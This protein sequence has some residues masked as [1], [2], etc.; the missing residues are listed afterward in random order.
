MSSATERAES[1]QESTEGEKLEDNVDGMF[2]PITARNSSYEERLRRHHSAS[3]HPLERNW[4]LN[5]GYSIQNADEEAVAE[6][7]LSNK[8]EEASDASEGFV[9]SWDDNDPMNP[10]N[11]NTVRRWLIVIICSAGSLCV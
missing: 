5:D 10:R 2:A 9:V 6:R 11:F 4:S 3:S 7:V 1:S 8:D